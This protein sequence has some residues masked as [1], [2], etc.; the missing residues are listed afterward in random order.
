MKDYKSLLISFLFFFVTSILWAQP[1]NDFCAGA[2]PITPST[3]G[4]GCSSAGFILPFTTDGTTDSGVPSVCNNPGKDQWFTWT[5]TTDALGFTSLLPGGPGIAVFANCADANAGIEIDCRFSALFDTTDTYGILSGWDIEDDLL[6]Q[7]YGLE[8]VNL[9]VDFCLEEVNTPPSN[10]ACNDAQVMTSGMSPATGTTLNASNV[11]NLTGCTIDGDCP[12]GSESNVEFGAGVWFVYTSTGPEDIVIDTEGSDFNTQIQVFTGTCGNFTCL[13][14]NDD[15][16]SG[17]LSKFCFTSTSVSSLAGG[18]GFVPIEYYIYLDGFGASQGNY[19]LNVNSTVLPI[20]LLSFEAEKK[21]KTNHL[22]WVT[23]SE[24]N[25]A[26]HLIER[27]ADGRDWK[28]I[29]EVAAAGFSTIKQ[30]Y[31]FTDIRPLAH[32]YYRLKSVDFDASYQLSNV[33]SLEQG[34]RGFNLNEIFPNPVNRMLSLDFNNNQNGKVEITVSDLTGRALYGAQYNAQD[35]LN[36]FEFDV[37]KLKS[38]I[39]VLTLNNGRIQITERFVKV[40]N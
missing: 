22:T 29:G 17:H 12:D 21:A 18:A 34:E 23:E 10:N 5:A 40:S 11:E 13:G 32:S 39:Y 30:Q 33:L 2:I 4:T 20:S 6:I 15:G 38:G 27:S 16:G 3:E 37:S 8:G 24:E 35:G 28:V 14:G 31:A 9:D 7:I 19:V 36:R 25:T 26:S 1:A